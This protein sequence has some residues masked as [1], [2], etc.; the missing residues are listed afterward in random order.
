M[1][2]ISIVGVDGSGKT[3]LMTALGDKYERADAFGL[4]LS[5]ET[6][7]AFN[8]VKL[9]MDRMRH[10]DWPGNTVA[11]QSSVLKWGL[12]QK[13]GLKRT[14]LCDLSFLDFSGEV[15]RLAFG[16]KNDHDAAT[17]ADKEISSAITELREHIKSS[18]T[19][20]TLVNLKDIIGGAIS[21][22]RTRESMW[23]FKAI[24]DYATNELHIQHIAVVFTQADA[25]RSTIE[26][27]GDVRG[28][29]EQYLPHVASKYPD[30]PILAVSAVNKTVPDKDGIPIP[31]EGFASDGLNF[32]MEW[33]VSTVPGCETLVS[34]IKTAPDRC[35]QKAEIL[36]SSYIQA[37]AENKLKRE[38]ILD[39]V[40]NTL[41]EIEN[42]IQ[43][44]P[45]VP[46]DIQAFKQ[47][48]AKVKNMRAF[49][50]T[51]ATL[52]DKVPFMV[53]DQIHKA[54]D[55]LCRGNVFAMENRQSIAM[56]LQTIKK[57]WLAKRAR[58]KRRIYIGAALALVF[59]ASV[60]LYWWRHAL[61]INRQEK[62]S[63]AKIARGWSY[64]Q[65]GPRRVAEWKPGAYHS[66]TQ[67]LKAAQEPDTWT[68]TKPGYVWKEGMELEWKPGVTHLQNKDLQS[69]RKTDTW[70]ATKPGYVWKGGADMAWKPGVT[71]PQNDDLQADLKK[72][73]WFS[74][75][76]GY[77][78]KGGAKTEW[79][80]DMRHPQNQDLK[81]AREQDVWI[82]TKPG[83]TW[84]EG[85]SMTWTPGV[86]HPQNQ[87]LKAAEEQ[88]KWVSTKPGYVW[89][90]GMNIVWTPGMRHPQNQFLRA[91]QE[92]CKWVATKPGYAWAGGTNIVWQE[93]L[94]N[95]QFPHWITTK[96]E[97]RWRLEDGYK[98][99]FNRQKYN[100]KTGVKLEYIRY[101]GFQWDRNWE[102]DDG[103][104][105]A[106]SPDGKST[107]GIF[108]YKID[109]PLC[110]GN[111]K[112]FIEKLGKR[113]DC[114][115]CD[116]TGKVWKLL[117]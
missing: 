52:S 53:D 87:F 9:Q 107:E 2:N 59:I 56:A 97:G 28:A 42:A 6:S 112:I 3:V 108:Y 17:Y 45:L 31:A 58:Q 94:A 25:Y 13:R 64:R 90:E 83:Y 81:S 30:M 78:W 14:H 72:D 11:G 8:Y 66:Q 57:E 117:P 92:E 75:K 113:V 116:K 10:G 60:S 36:F 32:L 61:E 62:D 19:L 26:E 33:I 82:A 77:V 37:L 69:G 65:E 47:L 35:Q 49:E 51:Y 40:Q 76:P 106:K 12:Y 29:Y 41:H 98:P 88:D 23:L 73:T 48:K 63:Q 67:D 38:Q 43:A 101:I 104:K 115:E 111:G 110:K 1:K 99:M 54:M 114:Q 7:E 91:A 95:N 16:S 93:G 70:I 84:V 68:S 24:L 105:K 85:T 55:D 79:E 109:C 20:I 18:D 22:V 39:S 27:C 34:D 103:N 46:H 80:P 21:D 15:Y 71:H 74:T 4:F 50:K 5:P 44:Y 102:S 96:Y 86:R 89:N 100:S